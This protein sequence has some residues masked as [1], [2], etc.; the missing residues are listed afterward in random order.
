MGIDKRRTI[1]Y[2]LQCDGLVE[3]QNRTL[4]NMLAAFASKRESDWDLWLDSVVYAHNTS[5]H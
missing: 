2:H 3:R 1:A 5:A 4:Q